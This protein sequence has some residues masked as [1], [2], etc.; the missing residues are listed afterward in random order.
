MSAFS[1]T[2]CDGLQEIAK[3]CAQR[4][5]GIANGLYLIEACDITSIPAPGSGTHTISTDITLDATKHWYLWKL[6]DVDN[7]FNSTAVGTKGAQT[8]QNVLTI[9]I[10]VVREVIDETINA[11]LNGEFVVCF[12]NKAGQKRLLGT[13]FAPAMIAQGGV[14]EVETAER[15]GVTIT[16]ENMGHTPYY[17]TGALPLTA[18]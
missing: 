2:C 13:E 6:G 16:F 17:Y 7:E 18:E 12:V 11:I 14:Q 5:N 9:F 3:L 10:P 15:S 8:F 1:G 4:T